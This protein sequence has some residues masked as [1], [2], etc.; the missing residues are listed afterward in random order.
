MPSTTPFERGSVILAE[1]LFSSGAGSK[2][3][4]AIVISTPRVHEAR[5]DLLIVPLTSNVTQARFG[6][7]SLSDW[8]AAGLPLPSLA[9]GVI[10]TVT[11]SVV[12]R[13]LGR[14]SHRDMTAIESSL[15]MVLGL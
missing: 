2:R 8:E 15:R 9:K 1:V 12:N 3:R 7:H 11:R 4:P 14:V 10:H 6:D 13:T 5:A